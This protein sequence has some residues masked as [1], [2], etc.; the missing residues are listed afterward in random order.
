MPRFTAL[1]LVLELAS[2]LVLVPVPVPVQVQV[3][4]LMVPEQWTA[5]CLALCA[6]SWLR[7]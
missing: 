7:T 4:V 1:V 2:V 5:W 3:Q 6:Q